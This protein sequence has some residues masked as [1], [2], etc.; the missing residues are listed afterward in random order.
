MPQNK[1]AVVV[2]LSTP[3]PKQALETIALFEPDGT[4]ID[5]AALNPIDGD[6]SAIAALSTTAYGRSTLTLVDASAA[7]TLFGA[8][9]VDSDL[10]AI[11]ALTTTAFGRGFLSVVDATGGRTLIGAAPT[12]SP[13]FTGAVVVPAQAAATH[14]LQTITST[15]AALAAV[16]NAINTSGKF[17]GKQ[18]FN[19]T[20][21]RPVFATAAT[22]AGTWV[23]SMGT[24][25]HTPV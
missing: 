6:L 23:D 5:L 15:T 11:A 1:Q 8:Q 19:T 24:T 2:V 10:T 21:N 9:P 25:A 14:A 20:T 13:T 18:V 16:G 12:A 22:A 7:Q 4:P 3:D 17:V